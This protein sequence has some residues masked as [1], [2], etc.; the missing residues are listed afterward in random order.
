[1][2]GLRLHN[3]QVVPLLGEAG[4]RARRCAQRRKQMVRATRTALLALA[5]P[6][7]VVSTA[8]AQDKDPRETEARKDCLTGKY[9]AGAALLAE[10]FT[11]TS[12]PNFIYNQARCYEQ[13]ARP[14]E[15]IQRF[16]E[17]LRIA[18][19]L[20]AEEKKEVENHIAECRP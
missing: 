8:F 12:N 10:L 3:Y 18:R 6:L 11:E 17:F 2:F 15:A 9:E 16:R 19:D 4:M 14:D 1:M 20:S 7:L 13:N 5:M